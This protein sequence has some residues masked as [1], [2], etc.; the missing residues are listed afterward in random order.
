MEKEIWNISSF[1]AQYTLNYLLK[2]FGKI[3]LNFDIKNYK[4]PP[5]ITTLAKEREVLRN[6]K[7]FSEA[8]NLRNKIKELGYIIEDTPLGPFIYKEN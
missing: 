4:I 5:K 7:R 3:G 6:N 1:K 2:F 8:D